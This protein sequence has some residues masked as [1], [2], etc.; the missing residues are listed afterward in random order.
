MATIK[1][2]PGTV[3]A[4][5]GNCVVY[6]RR[7]DRP[8]GRLDV[9]S[10]RTAID[11]MMR[12]GFTKIIAEFQ[13]VEPLTAHWRPA[14]EEAVQLCQRRKATLIIGKLEH[15]RSAVHWLGYVKDHG[16]NFRGA[17]APHINQLTL[18][19]LESAEAEWRKSVGRSVKEALVKAKIDGKVLGGDRGYSD[20]LRRG[21]SASAEA[22]A[23]R[24]YQRDTG[25]I[26]TI[27]LIQHRGVTS[28]AGIATRLNQMGISTP[29]GGPWG[30]TQV[31]RVINKFPEDGA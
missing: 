18:H 20:G 24:S 5:S 27:R 2:L 31:Q 3:R 26:W 11:S 15:M 30:P 28:L 29:R 12:P 21:P 17:D 16:V 19:F 7:S 13:E 23:K 14:L 4:L 10:Q 22:R 9:T 6:L 25:L 1:A 8:H